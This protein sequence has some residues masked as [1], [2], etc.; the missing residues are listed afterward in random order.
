MLMV[1]ITAAGSHNGD[2]PNI[3]LYGNILSKIALIA[4]PGDGTYLAYIE[5]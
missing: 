3:Y 4:A 5:A 1:N 2:S